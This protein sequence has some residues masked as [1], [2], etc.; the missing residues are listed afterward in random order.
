MAFV[1]ILYSKSLNGYYVGS[2]LDLDL[3]LKEHLSKKFDGGFTS[4]A[5]D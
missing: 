1:Y 3:R 5:S 4:K 2:C